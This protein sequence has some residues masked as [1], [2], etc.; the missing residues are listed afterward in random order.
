[1][2][3]IT[4][5]TSFFHGPKIFS[6]F[7]LLKRYYQVPMHPE[8]VSKTTV[9]TQFGTFTLNYSCFGL[10]NARVTFQQIMDSILGGFII[11]RLLHQ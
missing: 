10:R 8:V 5:V 9:T 4:N 3:I 11:L 2:P 1:M 7:D 6:K